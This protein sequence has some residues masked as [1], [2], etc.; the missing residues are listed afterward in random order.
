MLETLR[1]DPEGERLHAGNGFIPVPAVG[2]DA[3]QCWHFG[4]PA[5]VVLAF[6]FDRERHRRNVPFRRLPNKRFT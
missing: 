1:D 3:R 5:T 2:Q 4:D 6:N